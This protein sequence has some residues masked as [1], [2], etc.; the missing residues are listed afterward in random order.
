MK[1]EPFAT[2]R[3]KR[4]LLSSRFTLPPH[5][6]HLWFVRYA[7]VTDETAVQRYADLLNTDET[8]RRNRFM[9]ERDRRAYAVSHALLR[10]T[11]SHY[12]D[13]RPEQWSFSF[14]D[15]GRPE[16]A[17]PFEHRGLRFN[18]SHTRGAALVGVV[19]EHA[20]GV[21]LESVDRNTACVELADR[22]FSPS[23]TADLRQ[24]SPAEQ[25]DGFF[26]YWTLKEGYIKA[27]GMGL[28][29]PLDSFSY[30]L[31]G[32]ARIAIEFADGTT[33]DPAAWQ[34]VKF[35]PDPRFQ[36]AVAVCGAGRAAVRFLLRQTVP[37]GRID[38]AVELVP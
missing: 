1:Y 10:T 23:E 18:L 12:A 33:D 13:V 7:D 21:D 9:F 28:A 2:P 17:E 22:Y 14:N 35:R 19:R 5:E 24:L 37:L 31:R 6:V 32:G 11:L 27:R 16:I 15:Y 34:F 30:R 38:D 4:C 36:A 8:A 3:R 20:L 25:H 29:I 26:D